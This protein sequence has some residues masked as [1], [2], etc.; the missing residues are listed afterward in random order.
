MQHGLQALGCADQGRLLA[1]VR[2]TSTDWSRR[3]IGFHNH[4][5]NHV[6][7]GCRPRRFGNHVT[8]ALSTST[9]VASG[10]GPGSLKAEIVQCSED[11]LAV[12]YSAEVAG[13]YSL[14]VC[15]KITGEVR[16]LAIQ[17]FQYLGP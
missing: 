1:A 8:N 14:A 3:P 12:H 15:C 16:A 7:R 13:T 17:G 2:R 6:T 10:T 5:T 9:L 4:V 11:E